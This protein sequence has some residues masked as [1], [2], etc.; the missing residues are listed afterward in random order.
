MMFWR[1]ILSARVGDTFVSEEPTACT[2]NPY[3]TGGVFLRNVSLPTHL[4]GI[5]DD[6]DIDGCQIL[7]GF[8]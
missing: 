6:K 8:P 1:V 7:R 4:Y 3:V 2:S 5:T